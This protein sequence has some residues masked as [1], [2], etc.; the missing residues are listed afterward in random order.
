MYERLNLGDNKHVASCLKDL[1]IAYSGNGDYK[2]EL[3]FKIKALEMYERLKL[4]DRKLF[5]S[6]RFVCL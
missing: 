5:Y 6:C 4:S 1:G 3:E 2:K